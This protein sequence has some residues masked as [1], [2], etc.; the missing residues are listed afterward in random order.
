[1]TESYILTGY[2]R[3]LRS[4][5]IITSAGGSPD[6]FKTTRKKC[7][8]SSTM[9]S[10]SIDYQP[11]GKIRSP[12][13]A[14]GGSLSKD[15]VSEFKSQILSK[16]KEFDIRPSTS[17]SDPAEDSKRMGSMRADGKS[18]SPEHKSANT[19]QDIEELFIHKTKFFSSSGESEKVRIASEDLEDDVFSTGS[20]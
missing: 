10:K 8:K 17:S 2:I 16:F 12:Q 11:K 9:V 14:E 20:F 5:E 4:D 18:G 19:S 6:E 7:R 15:A 1:M 3:A 13:S